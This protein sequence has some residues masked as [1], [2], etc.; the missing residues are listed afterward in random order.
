MSRL[1]R[2]RELL[3]RIEPTGPAGFGVLSGIHVPPATRLAEKLAT[4]LALRPSSSHLVVGVIGSGKTTTV[5]AAAKEL[6]VH[7]QGTGDRVEY[8]DVSR[9]HQLDAEPLPGV[10]IA[11]AGL[12]LAKQAAKSQSITA[13]ITRASVA[14][15]RHAHGYIEWVEWD[16]EYED[17]DSDGDADDD[18]DRSMPVYYPGT[19]KPP[20]K[21]ALRFQ[22]LV[23][24][25]RVLREAGGANQNV[26][27]IFDSLDRLESS[28][29]FR[30]AVEHD[31]LILG[32][33]GIGTVVVGPMRFG[34]SPSRSIAEHFAEI[35]VVQTA[36]ANSAE[37]L[38]FLAQV[39]RSRASVEIMPD[40]SL[41]EIARASGGVLRDLLSIATRAAMDAYDLGHDV[42]E[43]IDVRSA[44]QA[45]GAAKAI[46]FDSASLSTLRRVAAGEAFK[47]EEQNLSM[48]E[49]GQVVQAEV[50]VWNVHPA[51]ELFLTPASEAA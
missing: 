28:A 50:G 37:G 32:R 1:A 5:R 40:G 10:L 33:A 31:I 15:R 18:G 30:D 26:I 38:A 20:A 11:L 49:R 27:F 35:H 8:V 48:V 7:V 44:V 3:G 19:L 2:Y 13:E 34:L 46:G 36:N 24:P 43:E 41:V 51:L 6:K 25:L 23:E 17:H 9:L 45:I 22:S 21:P 16:Q 39:L 42:I 4:A 29:R 47:L 12:Q 14:I